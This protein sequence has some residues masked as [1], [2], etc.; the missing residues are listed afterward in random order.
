[1]IYLDNAATTKPSQ[2][3][4]EAMLLAAESFGNPSSMYRL[5]L[6]SEKLINNTRQ[7]I[8]DM[9][10]VESKHIYFTSGGTEANNTAIFGEAYGRRKLGNHIITT[11]VEHPSVME[12]FSHLEKE[13][14]EVTFLG[15]DSEGLISLDELDNALREDTVLVSVMHVNNETGVIMPVDKIKAF[16]RK[17][18]PN[19]VLHCDCVQSFGK[20][21]V[22]PAVWGA[23]LVSISAHKIHGFKGTG[24]LYVNDTKIRP[25][26]FGGEQ[27]SKMR[28]GTENVAGI[29]AM[30]A[31]AKECKCDNSEILKLR[32]LF[33]NKFKEKIDNIK[34]NGSDEY[35]SGS[36]LNISF[37]GIKAEILLHSLERYEIYVSTGSACS[38]HKPQPSHVLTAM[39]LDREWINGAVR[40]SF[41][42]NI[43]EEDVDTVVAAFEK[44]VKAIRRFM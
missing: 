26:I 5:G 7:I 34:I 24:A 1:M 11:A 36:V 37:K 2:S 31:A 30:G 6:E 17:K 35:N 42:E 9:L 13:G 18:S 22:K 33:I 40:L 21:Q 20:L 10:G 12:A 14:F 4:V 38:S 29:L 25:L 43:K 28:P 32:K 23:D 15:V 16:M 27:Q 44:E 19:A 41:D 39:G 3:A 8:A